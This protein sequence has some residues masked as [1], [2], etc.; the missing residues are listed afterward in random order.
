MNRCLGPLGGRRVPASYLFGD[1]AAFPL[2]GS[3]ELLRGE[4]GLPRETCQKC[5]VH[6]WRVSNI[7][8]CFFEYC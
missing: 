6:S 2:W 3:I 5:H 7:N 4:G 8:H 1:E